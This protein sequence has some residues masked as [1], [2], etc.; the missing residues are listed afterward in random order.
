MPAEKPARA[1]KPVRAD[2][3]K[4]R[5]DKPA[6]PDRHFSCHEFCQWGKISLERLLAAAEHTCGEHPHNLC[7]SALQQMNPVIVIPTYWTEASTP[8]STPAS[9]T[10]SSSTAAATVA[11]YDHATPI[12][13][14]RPEL[15]ACLSSLDYVRGVMRV[16]V[17]VVAPPSCAKQARER[18]WSICAR[19]AVLNPLVIAAPEA[20]LISRSIA[21]LLPEMDG[22]TVSLRGYGA[23]RNMGLAVA[24]LL[25][26]D[27]VVFMD[28]D[29]L[30]LGPDYLVKAVYGIGRK[31]KQN[32]S[33]VA[34]TGYF[35]NYKDSPYA[36]ESDTAW[37]DKRWSKAQEFNDWM[38][39]ALSTTRISRSNYACGG[40]MT[41]H[42]EAFMRIGFDPFI[43]RGEDLD[44]LFN[45]RMYGFDMWFDNEWNVRHLPPPT[46]SQPS[47]FLQDVYRWEYERAKLA[48]AS[49]KVELQQV[50]PQSLMPYPGGWISDDLPKRTFWTSLFRAIGCPEHKAYLDIW[51]N[52]R[53]DARTYAQ[54]HKS[55]YLAFQ[56][57]WP[58]VM[59]QLWQHQQLSEK[60]LATG[61]VYPR[62]IHV[63]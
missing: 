19:H 37:Y 17:L 5:A 14:R 15:E 3:P 55:S 8:T 43:T 27:V 20:Q 40:C 26:H 21:Q 10:A 9:S 11:S 56:T 49:S 6:L 39:R 28:D 52:G 42:A 46:P 25:G 36:T 7:W 30:A 22:E 12:N 23:I 63:R 60:I 58:L 32:H 54:Q 51:L 50:S 16:V 41:L 45:L 34:K 53:T 4:P 59:A 62:D 61:Q 33:L 24:A 44:Y 47:R 31:T 29:E 13:Q 1:K 2:K 38:A 57:C 48:Y 18:V 35:L